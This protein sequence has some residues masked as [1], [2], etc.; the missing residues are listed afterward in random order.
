MSQ[1]TWQVDIEGQITDLELEALKQWIVEK[2]VLEHHKVKKGNLNWLEAGSAP[3]LRDAFRMRPA[4]LV[5]EMLETR[6]DVVEHM[7]VPFTS[8]Q[9]M[10]GQT[11]QVAARQLQ[12]LINTHSVQGWEFY[13]MDSITYVESPGCLA[14]LLGQKS[15]MGRIDVVIF[16]RVSYVTESRPSGRLISQA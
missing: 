2:R 12:D 1:E 14:S 11:A 8:I 15:V 16:R 7:V 3:P 4:P 5:P 9:Y 10:G 13:R 6:R